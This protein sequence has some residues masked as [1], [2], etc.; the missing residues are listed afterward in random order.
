MVKNSPS[1]PAI[2]VATCMGFLVV[3]LDVSVVN[4]GLAA[5]KTAFNTDLTGL[6]WVV[7]SY[8]L[9][10]SALLILGGAFGD[11]FGAKSTFATGFA[12]F[13]AASVG[14]GLANDMTTLITMRAVQGAGAALLVPTSLT[15]IRLSFQDSDRRKSAVA[16]WGACGGIALAAGPV[17]GGLL[18]QYLGWRSVF[19]INVPL[20]LLAIGLIMRFAPA[21]PRVDKK[22]DVAGQICIVIC[23]ATLTFALTESGAQGWN[24][25]T[26]SAITVAIICAGLF[27]GI[28]RRVKD[29]MLPPRLATNRVLMTMSLAGAVINF[30][31]FGTVFVFSIYF[32]NI[33][34]YDAFTTGL[35]FIPLTAVLTISTMVSSRI[36]RRVSALHIITTGFSLQ[37]MGFVALSQM[38]LHSSSPWLLN[39]ALMLVGI[40]SASSVPSITNSMLSSVSQHDAGIASG[41]MASA[42][43][44]G[45]VVGVAIFGA[46]IGHA[47]PAAFAKGMSE[48]MLLAVLALLLSISVNLFAAKQAFVATQ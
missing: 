33:L 30:T 2:L 35:S 41:F 43:Q 5:L 13:T 6:E 11:K 10:F 42:R 23:L 45:G 8:A 31:F 3:Q 17:L 18:I 40:G 27:M 12:V 15:L 19:L 29:P 4:V 7:N 34:H 25:Q 20:G 16:M 39:A 14:C 38:N 26:L 48:A 46:L 21:S 24:I 36:A 22:F 28:E 37:I 1:L 47:D 32:Q 9:V 44:L